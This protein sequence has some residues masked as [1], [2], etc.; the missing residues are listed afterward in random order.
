MNRSRLLVASIGGLAILA[1]APFT[2]AGATQASTDYSA[3][4][5]Q[6]WAAYKDA[7]AKCEP[8]AGHERDMC[9]VEAKAFEKRERAAAE[10][11]HN[12]TIEARTNSRIANA[13]ADFMVAKVACDVKTGQEKDI[14]VKQAKATQVKLVA[15]AKAHK[16]SA[17]TRAD[18]RDDS[19]EAQYRRALAKCEAMRDVEKDTCLTSAKSA[20]GK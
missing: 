1:F 5:E 9:I 8:L 2:F 15:Q 19:R 16:A 18:A 6:A 17:D 7:L 14:C 10:A 12:G 3:A 13:D 11:N 4:K 20:Y